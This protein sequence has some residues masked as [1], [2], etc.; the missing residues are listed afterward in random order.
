MQDQETKGTK[1]AVEVNYIHKGIARGENIFFWGGGIT[2][3]THML[4]SLNML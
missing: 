4:G 1:D 3:Y 2:E